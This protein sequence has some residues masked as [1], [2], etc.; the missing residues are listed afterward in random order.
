MLSA[1]ILDIDGTLLDTNEAHVEAWVEAFAA[2]DYRMPADRVRIEVGKGGD[3][4]VPS[5]LGAEVANR[6]GEELR[7]LGLSPAQC[8]MVG[9][10]IYDAQACI[11]AGVVC[12]DVATGPVT[13]RDLCAAGARGVRRNV[14][15]LLDQLD[16]A[17]TL[18]SPGPVPLT[19]ELLERLM[20]S[21]LDAARE[22]LA[23]GEAPIG[24]GLATTL[25]PCVMCTGATMET[26]VDTV[27]FGVRAP[28]DSEPSRVRPPQAPS[29][30]MPPLVGG[31]LA[32]E[33]RTLFETWLRERP[34]P[35]QKPYV[36]Q[37]L[38][39]T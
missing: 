28:G 11:G 26:A 8:A 38:A 23:S 19:W 21:A 33:S 9:D 12:L 39:L 22:G 17:L 35:E 13:A 34:N 6:E 7:R 30:G 15:E 29:T 2:R 1:L 3:Q 18:A 10:T 4:L 20:R 27:A 31:M 32:E 5:V 16:E 37:L 14:A 25:E 24:A 36:E